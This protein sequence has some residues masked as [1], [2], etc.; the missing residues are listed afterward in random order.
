MVKISLVIATY[1]AGATLEACLKSIVSQ[2]TP[3]IELLII[4]GGSSDNTIEIIKKYKESI[5]YFISEP[6]KGIYDAWNKGVTNAH[7]AWIMFL[8]ADDKLLEGSFESYSSFLKSHD[9][10]GVDIICG[11]C[12]YVNSK[13]ELL[14][15]R[16]D[17]YNYS[18][19]C[20]YMTISHGSSLHNKKLF[21]EIGGFN[22]NYKI[23]ADYELLIRKPLK[24][25][26]INR[27]MIEMKTGGMSFSI[28][29][30]KEA[31]RIRKEHH[32]VS[33]FVNILIYLR[34]CLVYFSKK[35]IRG[36]K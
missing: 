18:V 34:S 32:S 35:Y 4:D 20:R 15:I 8:G 22:L 25:L 11:K 7:G 19:M 31:Y 24:S 17:P 21:D 1:N 5:S 12:R 33:H 13:G 36:Y 3:E 16:G 10:I 6:D 23:C 2:I 14:G 29:G 28:K 26:F 27:P 30:L 9:T